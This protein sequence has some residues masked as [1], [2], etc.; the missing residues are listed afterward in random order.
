M[1]KTMTMYHALEAPQKRVVNKLIVATHD[2]D[3]NDQGLSR[4]NRL[5]NRTR[6]DHPAP[7]K[8][9]TAYME[10]YRDRFKK[11][12]TKGK[13]VTELAKVIG[14]EWQLLGKKQKSSYEHRVVQQERNP[15]EP[16]TPR[17][18]LK[19]LK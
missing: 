17:H 13:S 6:R 9:T 2:K 4:I 3:I 8:Q 12:H 11:L 14:A 7:R 15:N 5:I 18:L 1:T 19:P 16:Q 10:F